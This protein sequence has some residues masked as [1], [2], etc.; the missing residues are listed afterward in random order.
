M[1]E[2]SG[3]AV[4]IDI[5]TNGEIV[6]GNREYIRCCSTAAG[7]AFEGA[8]IRFGIGGV[9]GAINTVNLG[10]EGPIVTT[11][12]DARPIGICG[13]G[14]VD[15]LSML[16]DTGVVDETG[17]LLDKD[18]YAAEGDERILGAMTS[19]EDE[20]AILISGEDGSEEAIYMTQKDVREIQLA[21]ASIAAGIRTLV[22]EAGTELTDVS[23]VFIAGGFG[24]F[25]NQ[26]HAARIGLIPKELADRVTVIG[27]AA[28]IGACAAV[29]ASEA[30]DRCTAIAGEAGY[31]ELSSSLRFQTEYVDEMYFP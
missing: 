18:E 24:S 14:I 25:I 10:S 13:S 16:L 9:S 22:A 4:L 5:G 6:F 20:T 27:N 12:S 30:L 1:T 21:K 19:F 15:A 28:G 26:R 8:H 3:L 29:A 23:R 11:I 2:E 31:I 7:P 17:R